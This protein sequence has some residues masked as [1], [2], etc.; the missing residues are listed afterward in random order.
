MKIKMLFYFSGM[1]TATEVQT[2]QNPGAFIV[3]VKIR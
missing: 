2:A 1:R 3:E